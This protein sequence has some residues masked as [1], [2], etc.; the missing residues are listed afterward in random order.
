LTR[1]TEPDPDAIDERGFGAVDEQPDP[2]FL[3]ATM[4]VTAQWPAVRRLRAWERE[5]L[6][7]GPGGALLDVGCGIGEVARAYAA[8]VRPDGH[9]VGIDTSTAMLEVARD[10]ALA[11][12]VDVVFRTGDALAIDEP[13]ASF[14]ACRAERVLQWLPEL[15]RPVAEMMRVLRPGGRLC[16]IDT[17]W[18]TFAVDLPDL[19]LAARLTE[20]IVAYRGDGAPAGARLLNL[21]R[22]AG[23]TDLAHTATS[24]IWSAWD[25]DVDPGPAGLFPLRDV[26]D[27]VVARHGLDDGDADRFL[28]L[29]EG[30]ARADRLYLSVSMTAVC[31][32][33]S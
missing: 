24:H 8:D 22:D 25:P 5:H 29:L 2:S 17:D 32:R 7:L 15:E 27:D 14:D 31:G 18:R 19:A 28:D 11:A 3:V 1:R 12:G 4:D 30:A 26:L 16:L 6:A 23:L 9:V 33:V 20:A 13:D 10:R 21:C